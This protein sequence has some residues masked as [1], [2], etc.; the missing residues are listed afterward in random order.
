M[1]G[2]TNCGG[3]EG[4]DDR[5]GTMLGVVGDWLD[6][7][8]PTRTWGE[9]DDELAMSSGVGE[10]DAMALAEE[11]QKELKAATIFRPG[12][13]EDLCDYIYILCMGR[14]PCA[15]QIRDGEVPVP[16][17][18]G[19]GDEVHELYLRLA[20]SSVAPL[21]VVQQVSVRVS[22]VE[23]QWIVR[24]ELAAGV[25]DAPL[26]RRMQRL[27]ALLPAYELTH[28]DM[29]EISEPPEGFAHGD[30]RESYGKA[31]HQVNYLFFRNPST[32]TVTAPLL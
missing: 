6:R 26:L 18:L 15:L 12:S 27:V 11:L 7:L 22:E 16:E 17:E 32:M 5:K 8:Y 23:G 10:E 4:C 29:G 30:Y 3:K 14:E 9:I 19:A 25:Y 13:E 2:C 31:P 21:A 24:E 20:L 1:A 28:V